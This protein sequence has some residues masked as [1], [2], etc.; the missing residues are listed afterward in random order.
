[1]ERKISGFTSIEI[2]M[3]EAL[4]MGIIC[5]VV[6][7]KEPSC[8]PECQDAGNSSDSKERAVVSMIWSCL[9]AL[10]LVDISTK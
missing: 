7:P 5:C 2:L 6:V 4:G 9:T 10:D 3:F 1:M 8:G